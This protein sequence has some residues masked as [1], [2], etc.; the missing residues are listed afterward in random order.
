MLKR[1]CS[2]IALAPLALASFAGMPAEARDKTV[3]EDPD[4]TEFLALNQPDHAILNSTRGLQGCSIYVSLFPCNE[5][6]K[7]II[8]S[9]IT[10]VVYEQDKYD[11]TQANAA[12]KRMFRDAG[13]QLK[14]MDRIV[15]VDVKVLSEA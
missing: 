6:A 2:L 8:Q 13:V 4:I 1:L 11:G 12:S 14:K 10:K 5:C 7:A 9:G 3:P 15:E